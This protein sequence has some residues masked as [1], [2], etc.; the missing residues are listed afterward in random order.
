M[1]PLATPISPSPAVANQQA[2]HS[3]V[4]AGNCSMCV[5]CSQSCDR[6]AGVHPA[7]RISLQSTGSEAQAI[8][9]SDQGQIP[10]AHPL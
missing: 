5:S 3:G 8:G 1:S 10:V 4:T 9:H 7:A 2:H 6:R